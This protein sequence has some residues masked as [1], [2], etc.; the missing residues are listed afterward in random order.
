MP[1]STSIASPARSPMLH[2]EKRRRGLTL[3]EVLV[4]LVIL[5]TS[6]VAL[7]GVVGQASHGMRLS[8]ERERSVETAG[9]ELAR[10][11]TLSLDALTVQAGVHESH[12]WLVRVTPVAD[13]LFD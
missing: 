10:V 12:R 8:R 13:G 1:R 5:G 9:L 4:A 6:A 11:S 2:A 7:I 3:L